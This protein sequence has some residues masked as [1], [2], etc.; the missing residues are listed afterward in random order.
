MSEQENKFI[1]ELDKKFDDFKKESDQRYARMQ[2]FL[3]SILVVLLSAALIVGFTHFTADGKTKVQV[4]TLI[5]RQNAVYQQAV[6]KK[7]LNELITTYDNQTK[8]MAK[9]LPDDVQGAI[10]AFNKA[11]SDL[12]DYIRAN[13]EGIVVEGG[14][15]GKNNTLAK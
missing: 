4:E 1:G 12:R 3:L 10:E 7:N 14:G 11:S 2:S 6:T 8:I 9:F 13:Q 5:I 15:G